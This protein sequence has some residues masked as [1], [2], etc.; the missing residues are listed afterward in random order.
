MKIL[1]ALGALLPSISSFAAASP[2]PSAT[3]AT[4]SVPTSVPSALKAH[5]FRLLPG[6]DFTESLREW[7]R[8]NHVKAAAVVT[9]VGSFTQFS[10]RYANEPKATT[11][12]G[13]FE[14]VSVTGTFN[15]SSMH[16]HASVSDNKG[17]T[18]GGHLTPGNLIY[19]T[20]EVVVAEL[21]DAVFTREKDPTFGWDELVVR[22]SQR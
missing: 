17:V 19:T 6:Q 22:P 4:P 18:Y 5:A 15:E 10:L 20:A 3:P 12:K 8:V 16:L 9:V 13:H 1:L 14:I 21:P 2:T 7:A 11:R